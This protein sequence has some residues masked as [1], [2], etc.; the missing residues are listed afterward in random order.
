MAF[1]EWNE[2]LLNENI[3][4]TDKIKAFRPATYEWQTA[5]VICIRNH[6]R[7]QQVIIMIMV[8]L[9]MV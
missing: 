3:K 4:S 2:D 7:N 5:V 6:G 9:I 8:V 1:I